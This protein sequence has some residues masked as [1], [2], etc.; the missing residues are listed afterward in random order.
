MGDLVLETKLF[1][2]S[3]RGSS[4][5]ILNADYKS[6]IEYDIPNMIDRDESVEYIQFSIPYVTKSLSRALVMVVIG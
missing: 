2:L 5:N 6:L 3:T 4:G 1:N